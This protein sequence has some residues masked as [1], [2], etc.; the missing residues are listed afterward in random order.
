MG[1]ESMVMGVGGK[2]KRNMVGVWGEGV[3]MCEMGK[4]EGKGV[5]GVCMIEKGNMWVGMVIIG[6]GNI[7]V[8]VRHIWVGMRNMGEWR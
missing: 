8:R 2:G 6:N 4:G 7:W 5:M 1:K 3:G